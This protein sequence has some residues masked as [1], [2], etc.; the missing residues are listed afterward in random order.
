MW[1]LAI[2]WCTGG[3][4]QPICDSIRLGRSCSCI[5]AT[6]ICSVAGYGELKM[7]GSGD[8][9]VFTVGIL[10]EESLLP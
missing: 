9:G 8:V 7:V 1:R 4:P 10:G 5:N 2:G 6:S 3:G